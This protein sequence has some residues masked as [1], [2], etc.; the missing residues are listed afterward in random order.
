MR[1]Y[2]VAV[3]VFSALFAFPYFWLIGGGE[4]PFLIVLAIVLSL[5]L[6]IGAMFGPQAAYFA[7]LFTGGARFTGLAFSR[8]LAGAVSAGTT[9]LIA[10]A[11]VAVTGGATWAVALFIIVACA[12]GAVAVALGG[13]T[14]G[15]RM[16][17]T[18]VAELKASTGSF[19]R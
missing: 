13:E 17:T 2:S 18:T 9:P 6:G 4:A 8:E 19:E 16:S 12:L 7:E 11:L 1:A 3:L 10:V 15:R 5:G 14:R